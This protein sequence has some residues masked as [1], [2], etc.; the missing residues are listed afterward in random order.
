MS[1]DVP[2]SDHL[3]SQFSSSNT[4]LNGTD[5]RNS[6]Y[7]NEQG[8]NVNS[9]G[10]KIAGQVQDLLTLVEKSCRAE[11]G[12]STRKT[13]GERVNTVAERKKTTVFF[14]GGGG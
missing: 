4:G 8:A 14:W 7:Q 12:E 10:G 9:D 13:E 3:I 6:R 11:A 1:H 2:W 5:D